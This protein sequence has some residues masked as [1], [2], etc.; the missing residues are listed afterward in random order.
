MDVSASEMPSRSPLPRTIIQPGSRWMAFD[1]REIWRNRELLYF[2]I[3]RDLK[4][5]YKQTAFG[6]LWAL[7]QPLSLM[8]VFSLFLGNVEGIAPQGVPYSLF[9][10]VALVPWTLFSQSLIGSSDSLVGA[11]NILQKVYF[12]RVL[13]PIAAV[14]SYILDF[15]IGMAMLLVLLVVMGWPPGLAALWTV[16]LT[17]L[18]VLASLAFGVW[19][20]AV[21]VRYRDVRYAVPF[22]VQVWLFASPVAYSA[23]VVP[24][25]L[26]VVYQLNPMAGVIEGFRWALLGP[27]GAAPLGALA[28]STLITGAVLASGLLYFRRVER[29]FA[30]VI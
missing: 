5:R 12:P 17:V 25:Q 14:G 29:T 6:A 26:R 7:I 30:D 3:W 15:L 18:A 21:N 11:A 8:L 16:P 23:A 28:L 27:A 4:V 1:L 19:L 22:L 9:T 13:L 20:S 24:E 2:F 10:L